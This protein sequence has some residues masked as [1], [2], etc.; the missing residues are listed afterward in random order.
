MDRLR[1]VSTR[2]PALSGAAAVVLLAFAASLGDPYRSG[3]SPDPS[4]SSESIAVAIAE[5]RGG[6]RLSVLLG[7]IGAFFLIWFV[8]YLQSYLQRFEGRDGWMSSVAFGGGLVATSL[9]LVSNSVVLAATETIAYAQDPVV[10]K[11]FLTHGWNYFFVVSPPLMALVA[12][13]SLIGLR[14]Q[15]LP[16]WL[17]ILGLIM[18]VLPFFAGA[19][20]GAMLGLLWILLT[21]LVLTVTGPALRKAV[22][23]R[24]PAIG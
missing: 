20:L 6:A 17:A 3:L 12:A 10:A 24:A 16:R 23:E 9:L 18:L 22:K 14:F 5:I 7:L 2:L 19:G 4:D 13:S 21:S 8:G 11:V 1:R 15:A